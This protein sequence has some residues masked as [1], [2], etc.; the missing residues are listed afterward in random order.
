MRNFLLILFLLTA[1]ASCVPMKQYKADMEKLQKAGL[2]LPR[3]DLMEKE[4]ADLKAASVKKEANIT[5]LTKQVHEL[6]RKIADLQKS[7]TKSEQIKKDQKS[8]Y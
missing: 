7:P 4:I 6:E 2:D 3:L 1:F 5:K 8:S